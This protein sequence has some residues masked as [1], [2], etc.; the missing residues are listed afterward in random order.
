M[1]RVRSEMHELLAKWKN[2]TVKNQIIAA[3]EKSTIEDTEFEKEGL[4][5]KLVPI[6]REARKNIVEANIESLVEKVTADAPKMRKAILDQL[7]VVKKRE[8]N[9]YGTSMLLQEIYHDL[10]LILSEVNY[11]DE[12]HPDILESQLKQLD[13]KGLEDLSRDREIIK[14]QFET[15]IDRALA[16]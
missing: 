13:V 1:E 16:M 9:P 5:V 7:K 8:Q 12:A 11:W 15:E 10:Y 4:L 2:E 6:Y 3:I 14:E